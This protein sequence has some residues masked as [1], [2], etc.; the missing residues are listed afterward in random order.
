MW[1]ES[2]EGLK[3]RKTIYTVLGFAL[4]NCDRLLHP[5]S[6]Y[7]TDYLSTEAFGVDSLVLEEWPES[8]PEFRNET[9]EVEFDLLSKLVSITNAAR[10]RGKVKRRWPLRKAFYLVSKDSKDLVLANKGLLLELTNLENLELSENPSKT[11]L[12]VTVKLNLELVA[13]RAKR[14]LSKLQEV[15]SNSNAIALYNEMSDKGKVKVAGFELSA[16]D[17]QFTFTSSDE[18][19]A[20]S[21]NFGM[22]VALDVSRDDELL[23]KGLLRDVARNLQSLRKEKKFNPTDILSVAT[24]A[25][26]SKQAY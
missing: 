12:K 13:P 22:V 1:E 10:M 25:G 19:Y 21:E 6:P 15:V 9:L 18:K 24:V 8:L 5:I 17:L 3:R 20:V 14:D 16:Q 7:L 23:A 26:L 11:P 2:E 4:L